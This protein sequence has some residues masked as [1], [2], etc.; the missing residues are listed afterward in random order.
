VF[1]ELRVLRKAGAQFDLIVLDTPSTPLRQPAR[2][3][4]GLQGQ[5]STL[6]AAAPGGV[7]MTYSC[8][9]GIGAGCSKIV[10]APPSMS[11]DARIVRPLGPGRRPPGGAGVSR[12]RV[13]EGSGDPG[14]LSQTPDC[15]K[16][17]RAKPARKRYAAPLV[18]GCLAGC[19][20]VFFPKA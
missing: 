3:V 12:G 13:P 5:T 11:C 6:Q 18:A 10:A 2:G 17:D 19:D 1:D 15:G 7:L 14:R 16:F 4:E 8:S 20:N 9:G